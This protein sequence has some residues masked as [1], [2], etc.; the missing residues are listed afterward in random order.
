MLCGFLSGDGSV[1]DRYPH[2]EID[3][4]PDDKKVALIYRGIFR[5]LYN[6]K[7]VIR[8]QRR[9]FG[10]CF[11]LRVKY[12]KAFMHLKSLTTFGRLRWRVPRFVLKEYAL[13]KAWLRAFFDCEGYVN[14]NGKVIQIQTVNKAGLKQVK[15]MLNSLDINSNTYKYERKNKNWNTNYILCITGNSIE[16]FSSIVGFN[17]SRKSKMLKKLIFKRWDGRIWPMRRSRNV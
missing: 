9:Y 12:K 4:Y 10:N 5:D 3:F 11:S 16:N 1:Q 13:K 8:K 17:H 15:S 7:L 14:P 6:K 2:Y